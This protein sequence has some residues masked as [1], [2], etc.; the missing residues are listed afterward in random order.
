M[1]APVPVLACQAQ[2]LPK[3][4]FLGQSDRTDRVSNGP[5][6]GAAIKKTGCAY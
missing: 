1:H 6:S 5:M 3:G 4:F 2:V